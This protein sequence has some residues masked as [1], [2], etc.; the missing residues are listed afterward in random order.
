MEKLR[1]SLQE[2]EIIDP[3]EWHNIPQPIVSGIISLKSCVKLQSNFFETL[4]KQFTDFEGRCNI[5]ILNVQK[6]LAES[7]DRIRDNDEFLKDTLCQSE[8]QIKEAIDN[9]Q[10]KITEAQ[11]SF[12]YDL[13]GRMDEIKQDNSTVMKKIDSIP[14]MIQIQTMIN[15]AAEKVKDSVKQDIR[16]RLFKPEI[17]AINQKIQSVN[18]DYEGKCGILAEKIRNNEEKALENNK[19][20]EDWLNDAMETQRAH[21]EKIQIMTIEM[22][23]IQK[24]I[25]YMDYEKKEFEM[26]NKESMLLINAL[27]QS[28]NQEFKRFEINLQ[29]CESSIKNIQQNILDISK[30]KIQ[31]TT[32]SPA[33]PTFASLIS[34]IINYTNPTPSIPSFISPIINYSN[35]TPSIPIPLTTIPSSSSPSPSP[36]IPIF[37][38]S[39]EISPAPVQAIQE[40]PLDDI[41]K[42]INSIKQELITI[43]N[44]EKDTIIDYL[45]DQLKHIEIQ[46]EKNKSS[47]EHAID[48]LKD[49]LAWLPI[50][51]SQLENMTPGEARLFTIEARLRSE[52]NSRIH[53]F[54]HLSKLIENC[55]NQKNPCYDFQDLKDIKP[56]SPVVEIVNNARNSVLRKNSPIGGQNNMEWWKKGQ[57]SERKHFSDSGSLIGGKMKFY[58]P[59]PEIDEIGDVHSVYKEKRRTKAVPKSW[60]VETAQIPRI[61]TAMPSKAKNLKY[62]PR[63]N[64][65]Y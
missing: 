50:S 4:N 55:M 23:K 41:Y 62:F 38:S 42:K 27:K 3:K 8:T 30:S 22:I 37:P 57:E 20:F 53:A 65:I 18:A 28:C 7:Q 34:P 43:I 13:E 58:T 35:P 9:F 45:Q 54:N 33:M 1:E 39:F 10:K 44:E 31:Q 24:K 46:R 49:K 51:L 59:V 63:V 2:L 21:S 16:D 47:S 5:R 64:K 36:S 12:K 29:N 32:Y 14:S 19:N 61:Q 6:A 60:D 40:I 17:T 56:I 11:Y 26:K 52:E 15:N 48:E 25:E